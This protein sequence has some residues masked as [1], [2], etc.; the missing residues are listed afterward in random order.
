MCSEIAASS[1]E[2]VLDQQGMTRFLGHFAAGLGVAVAGPCGLDAF[3]GEVLELDPDY[4]RERLRTIFVNGQPVDDTAAA[5]VAPGD[6]VA[7]SVAMPGLVGICMRLD[8]PLKSFRGDI[9]H[10]RAASRS[11][12]GAGTGIV[13]LK[14]FN[15]IALELGP[16]LLARGVVLDGGRLAT[17]LG[18][19]E[20]IVRA[21]CDGRDCDVAGLSMQCLASPQ[22]RHVLRACTA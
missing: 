13:T 20:G 5:W 15:F 14:L 3:F 9:T 8:S 4:V 22:L 17:I 18:R 7:L 16:S 2:L 21:R 10:G 12:V 11:P 6:E 19:G 1:I